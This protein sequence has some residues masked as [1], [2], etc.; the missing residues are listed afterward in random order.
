MYKILNYY[1]DTSE[2]QIHIQKQIQKNFILYLAT[3]NFL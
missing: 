3:N 1:P 2:T